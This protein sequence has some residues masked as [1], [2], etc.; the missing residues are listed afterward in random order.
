[1]QPHPADTLQ[2]VDPKELK[3]HALDLAALRVHYSRAELTEADVLPDPLAQFAKWFDEAAHAQLPEPNAL[4]LA[5]VDA[6]GQP[7][8]RV[9]LLKTVREGQ[10]VFF[11][12]YTSRK[13][14]ELL[15]NPLAAMTWHWHELER[16][17][18]VRGHVQ[19]ATREETATYFHQRPRASQ[20]GAW[21]SH[22]STAT[23][24]DALQ[25]RFEELSARWEGQEIPVPDFWGGFAL[26]PLAIEFWQGRP[27]RLHDRIEFTRATAMEPWVT[28]RLSP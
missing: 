19:P 7:S 18:C 5:T 21:V 6:A 8:A 12:N 20:I 23:S 16:Q 15:A 22:Q 11:T 25:A 26:T 1:M 17:V 28:Q 4:T 9:V 2:P 3:A 13:G 24:R 27:S 10:F 14:R